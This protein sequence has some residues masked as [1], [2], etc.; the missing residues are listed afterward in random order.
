MNLDATNAVATEAPI[1]PIVILCFTSVSTPFKTL[2]I[3]L[4]C[5]FIPVASTT[6]VMHSNDPATAAIS[7]ANSAPPTFSTFFIAIRTV[8]RLKGLDA[9]AI[10]SSTSALS[11]T[12]VLL[13]PEA[14]SFSNS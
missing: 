5:G 6:F 3:V 11:R 13:E 9:T 4:G 7:T 8:S 1:K 14:T 2:V 12:V 10:P